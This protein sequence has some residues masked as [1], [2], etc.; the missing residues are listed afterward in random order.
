MSNHNI[1]LWIIPLIRGYCL[2]RA[3]PLGA[4]I[5]LGA[6]VAAVFIVWRG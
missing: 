4:A 3:Y 2:V 1:P 6:A 5:V